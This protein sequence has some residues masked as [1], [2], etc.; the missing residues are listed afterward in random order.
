MCFMGIA[1]FNTVLFVV[2]TLMLLFLVIFERLNTDVIVPFLPM[3]IKNVRVFSFISYL[4]TSNITYRSTAR[5]I[6][7]A[8]MKIKADVIDDRINYSHYHSIR[9][10][11][12]D[13]INFVTEKTY[14]GKLLNSIFL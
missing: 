10:Y 3:H 14:E 11:K 12:I 2:C 4:T 1:R 9:A 7:P 6:C 13:Y 8:V 5:N